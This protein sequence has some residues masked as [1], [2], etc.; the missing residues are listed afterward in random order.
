MQQ[1]LTYDSLRC[2]LEDMRGDLWIGTDRGVSH[3]RGGV[4]VQ[5]AAT[6]AMAQM[7]VWAIHE[8]SNGGLWFGTRNNGLFRLQSGTLAQFTTADGLA[9]NAIYDILEDDGGHLWMSGPNGISM[10]NRSELDAQA[11]AAKR[12]FALTFY[13]IAEMAANTEIYGGTQS[14]GCIT[15]AGDVW[16]PSNR[17]PIHILPFQRSSF[18]AP[19]LHIEQVLAD[20]KPVPMAGPISLRSEEH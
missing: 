17:G 1:G 4:F 18:A 2:L 7:K 6:A 11:G 3:M 10:L 19:R 12:H 8:D 13:S 5:D 20:G 16:I 9:S 14:S 15:A